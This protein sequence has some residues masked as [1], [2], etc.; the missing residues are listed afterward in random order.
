[1]EE[2][3]RSLYLVS[4]QDPDTWERYE[5]KIMA[6]SRDDAIRRV[7]K[8]TKLGRLNWG[9]KQLPE[10]PNVTILDGI[11]FALGRLAAIILLAVFIIPIEIIRAT[12]RH[13]SEGR[14]K[15]LLRSFVGKGYG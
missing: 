5:L 11:I 15:I 4:W 10:H 14:M 3:V 9:A 13:L 2:Q 7:Q 12:I 1:M 8:F 6:T